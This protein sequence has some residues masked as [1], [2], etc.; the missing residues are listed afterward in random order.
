MHVR[1]YRTGFLNYIVNFPAILLDNFKE[2]LN[3]YIEDRASKSLL[4]LMTVC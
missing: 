2:G 4:I 3:R 1:K